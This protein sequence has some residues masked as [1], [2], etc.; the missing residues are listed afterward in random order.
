MDSHVAKI[1][2]KHYATASLN[3]K[4]RTTHSRIPST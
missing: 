4:T 2:R 3:T 1:E